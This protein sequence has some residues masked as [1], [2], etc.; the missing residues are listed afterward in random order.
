MIKSLHDRAAIRTMQIIYVFS[1][2][3]NKNFSAP[4]QICV[5]SVQTCHRNNMCNIEHNSANAS[6]CALHQSTP[7]ALTL[8]TKHPHIKNALVVAKNPRNVGK[9]F[10][11]PAS[12]KINTKPY[13][14]KRRV[15]V[16][17]L[18]YVASIWREAEQAAA[19][20]VLYL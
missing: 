8:G 5:W 14:I 3:R 7:P 13:N 19:C 16:L 17:G 4:T 11:Y 18:H 2:L 1:E 6:R 12:S 10:L 9:L 15:V 20:F